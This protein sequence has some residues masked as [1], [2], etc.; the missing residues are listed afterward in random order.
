M[1]V[2]LLMV[3]FGPKIDAQSAWS[4]SG[5]FLEVGKFAPTQKMDSLIPKKSGPIGFSPHPD[6]A[7]LEIN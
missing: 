1:D 4:L 6:S 2:D 3:A 7:T 5:H